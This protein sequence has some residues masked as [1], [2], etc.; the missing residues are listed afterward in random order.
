MM[1][2]FLYTLFNTFSSSVSGLSDIKVLL[3]P[4]VEQKLHLCTIK[5]IF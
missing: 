1:K 4:S 2:Y 3:D 5:V